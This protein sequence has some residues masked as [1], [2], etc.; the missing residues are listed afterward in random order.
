MSC[1]LRSIEERLAMISGAWEHNPRCLTDGD[2]GWLIGQ[3]RESLEQG[4]YYK[5]AMERLERKGER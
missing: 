2:V 4:A 1:A 5:A 3:L